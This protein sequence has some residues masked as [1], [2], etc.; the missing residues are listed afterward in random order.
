M[1]FTENEIKKYEAPLSRSEE[2]RCKNAIRMV[3][4]VLKR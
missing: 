4:D 1:V 2:E 3:R